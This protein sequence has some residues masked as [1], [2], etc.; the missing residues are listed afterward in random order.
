[1]TIAVITNSRIPSL[2]A[3][4]MQAMKVCDALAQLGHD[5]RVFAPAEALPASWEDLARQYGLRHP[6][7]VEWLP[8]R[9]ALKRFDFVWYAQSAAQRFGRPR[10]W[11]TVALL[12]AAP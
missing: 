5:L 3:N 7:G 1:M 6:F 11:R 4:S 8:S 2:T 10:S 9:R 12:A